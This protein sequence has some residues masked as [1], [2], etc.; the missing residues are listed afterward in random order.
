[1]Y[2][3]M[4]RYMYAY[5]CKYMYVYMTHSFIYGLGGRT[6]IALAHLADKLP[7]LFACVQIPNS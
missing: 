4:Y 7:Q 5:I 2:V 1:M 6:S 3:Y